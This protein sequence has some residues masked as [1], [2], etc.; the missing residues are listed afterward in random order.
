VDRFIVRREPLATW[1]VV[2]LYSVLP[3]LRVVGHSLPTYSD[4][5]TSMRKSLFSIAAASVFLA[6]VGLASADTTSTTTTTWTNDQGTTIRE[7]S[8]S[9]HYRSFNDPSLQ[10]RVGMELPG[11]VTVYPL[12]DTIKVPEPDRYSYSIINDHPVVVERTTRKVIH[13][14]DGE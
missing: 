14:W 11:T 4:E 7:Y 2:I 13:T 8:T 10:P 6:G 12:P 1:V 9:N 5:E 3:F